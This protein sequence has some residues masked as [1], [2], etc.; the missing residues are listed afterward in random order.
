[1]A[2]PALTETGERVYNQLA[3]TFFR[4]DERYGWAGALF[5]SAYASMLDP[6]A[7]IVQSNGG[8]PGYAILF[9]PASCPVAWLPWL[10]QFVGIPPELS[11][12]M[13][14][15]GQVATLRTWIKSP[16]NYTR[17]KAAAMRLAGEATL[18]GTKTLYFYVKYGGVAFEVKAASL[19]AETP[20]PTA[21]REAIE[22]M[23]GAWEVLKYETVTG[24]TLASFE[25]AH[26][27]LSESEAA[28]ATVEL[29][30]LNP[31]K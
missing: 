26:P 6:A 23:M 20:S 7:Q 30:E 5:L 31:T 9:E 14:K 19:V 21:T 16:I 13:V 4:E 29:L 27:K 1:M 3:P 22:S 25:A 24:G 12:A 18:T 10:G 8:H 28:N 11:L 17:G 15:T 2:K